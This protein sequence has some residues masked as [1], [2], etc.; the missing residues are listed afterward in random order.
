MLNYLA[1]L[2]LNY[3]HDLE[4]LPGSAHQT[5]VPSQTFRSSDGYVVVMC[6][7]EKFWQRFAQLIG[8]GE[9]IDDARF[10]T[11]HDRLAHRGELIAL[12][13]AVLLSRTTG[14]WVGVL[15]GEVPCAPVYTVAEA[16]ADEQVQAREMVVEVMHPLFGALRQVGCPVKIDDV[17]PRYAPASSY[18]ADTDELLHGLLGMSHDEIGALRRTGAI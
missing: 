4:R 12:L 1:A 17:E 2:N 14:E 16:L 15:R 13:Q 11:F 5:L 6:M 10:R 9:L 7:K 3:G 18:A 8:A